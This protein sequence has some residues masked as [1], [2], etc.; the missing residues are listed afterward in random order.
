MD[1][2]D[3]IQQL[4]NLLLARGYL[5]VRTVAKEL[6]VSIG[7]ARRDI[8]SLTEK[9][10][11]V[12]THGGVYLRSVHSTTYENTYYNKR[13]LMISEKQAIGQ[14]AGTLVVPGQSIFIDG[15]T[16]TYEVARHIRDERGLT[17]V[18]N[19]V[20]ILSFLSKTP[21]LILID[22][23]GIVRINF[24]SLLGPNTVSFIAGLHLNIVFLGTDF[25]DVF[26][27]VTI[28][29]QEEVAVKRAMI[30]AADRVILVCDHS[31][32]G[33]VAF[34]R[35]CDIQSVH[36]IVTDSGISPDLVGQIRNQGVEV[37]IANV[38]HDNQSKDIAE[39]KSGLND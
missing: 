39:E 19:D 11:A 22:P 35:V 26:K 27:G 38:N 10:L 23:G 34:T 5:D 33:S 30:G 9:D 25:V 15:G 17:V 2:S 28:A 13:R 36:T 29:N 4:Q 6:G 12:R 31:K 24:G 3:R 7:T 20:F 21:G 32:F 18:C 1:N 14:L 16:T 8:R 37:L